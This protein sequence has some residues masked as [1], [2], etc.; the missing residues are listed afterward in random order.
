[1][2]QF[3]VDDATCTRCRQCVL[4]CPSLIIEQVGDAV[5]FIR[6]EN[7]EKCVRCQHCLAVCPPAAV[8]IFGRD[9]ADSLPLAPCPFPD[10]EK[11]LALVRG[12]RSVR[13]YRDENVDPVLLKRLLSALSNAPSGVNRMARTLA[14]IDDKSAMQRF[15]LKAMNG[16]VELEK[17]GGIPPQFGYLSQSL[18]A[19]SK[20]GVD[21]I[22]RGAPH[23]LVVS[24][25]PDAFCPEEDVNLALAYF[26]L[27]AQVA[28][29]GT[30]WCGMAKMAMELLPELKASVGLKP[31]DFYYAMLFGRPS[32][33][34][35][36]TVQ[37][38]DAA[39][40]RRI[41]V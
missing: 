39:R 36:R 23:L 9:P 35:A 28:G 41:E 3:V 14:V 25:A 19:W 32:F 22:F 37:R 17:A 26:E 31:G 21:V 20:H 11:M 2:L 8:S 27:M 1:M 29:L 4:D 6:P 5:P 18:P 15:R 13:R 12:R 7:E 40:V 34:Y 16:L 38:D 24:A 30:V 33:R 10:L